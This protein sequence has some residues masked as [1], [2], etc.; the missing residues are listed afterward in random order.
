M[1]RDIRTKFH[2]YWYRRTISEIGEAGI[3]DGRDLRIT[4][5]T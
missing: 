1:W 5:L 4:P 2:E 3:T